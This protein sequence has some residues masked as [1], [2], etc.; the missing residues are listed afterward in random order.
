MEIINGSVRSFFLEASISI[1]FFFFLKN[2]NR[3]IGAVKPNMNAVEMVTSCLTNSLSRTRAK[4]VKTIRVNE[5]GTNSVEIILA[6][7]L[8]LCSNSL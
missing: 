3:T 7:L 4:I 5:G 2:T 6:I 8:R 1:N